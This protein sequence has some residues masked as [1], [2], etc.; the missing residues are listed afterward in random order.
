MQVLLHWN[1]F[2][3][4]NRPQLIAHSWSN[5]VDEQIGVWAHQQWVHS[6]TESHLLLIILLLWLRCF[7]IGLTVTGLQTQVRWTMWQVVPKYII[8]LAVKQMCQTCY[9]KLITNNSDKQFIF[10]AIYEASQLLSYESVLLF[11]FISLT[12]CSNKT[13]EMKMSSLLLGICRG[14]FSL[15]SDLYEGLKCLLLHSHATL[16]L[17]F[18]DH[19]SPLHR[20]N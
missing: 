12:C 15:L 20:Q 1:Q 4:I 11:C 2:K 19:F 18:L 17:H 14:H 5:S 7:F 6:V 8:F 3:G 9:K 13:N 10:S 16:S